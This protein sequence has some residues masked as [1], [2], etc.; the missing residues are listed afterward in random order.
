MN[1]MLAIVRREY[2]AFFRMPLGWIV[3][4]LFLFLSG[5]VFVRAALQ[6]GEPASMRD[7][8]AFWWRVL[9][10]IS[11]AISMRLLAEEHRTG[12]IDTVL[13]SPVNEVSIVAGK[14]FASLAFLITC[15]LPTL[16]YVGVLFMLA[17]PDPGPIIAGYLGIILLGSL[18]LALGLLFSSLTSSQTLAFLATLFTLILLETGSVWLAGILPSPWDSA[19]LALSTELRI[20]DFAKGVIDTGHV[21]YFIMVTLWLCGLAALV[22]RVRRWR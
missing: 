5:V 3:A 17:R 12:T 8:F 2:A 6:P 9:I 1:R 18:Q 16:A 11:P 19:S 10:V 20:G 21:A 15:L 13:S 14:F 4:A 7:F 22:L